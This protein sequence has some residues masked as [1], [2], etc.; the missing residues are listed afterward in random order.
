MGIEFELDGELSRVTPV[1]RS[2]GYDLDVDGRRVEASLAPDEQ[3]G[4]E[5]CWRL[6]MDGR[7]HEVWLARHG[8]EIFVH[9]AGR[10]HRIASINSLERAAAEAS[11][12]AGS[13]AVMA[14]MPGVVVEVVTPVGTAVE[15]NALLMTI[16]SMK[17]QTPILAPQ[18]GVVEEVAFSE[19]QSFDKGALLVRLGGEEDEQETQA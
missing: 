5:G 16:E 14:P 17:L 13:G 4:G 15:R 11:G 1:Y 8:D 18:D 10:T 6:E 19:G 2:G 9:H 7:S 12:A 3:A